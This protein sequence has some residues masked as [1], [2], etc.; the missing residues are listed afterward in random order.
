VPIVRGANYTIAGITSAL[1]AILPAGATVTVVPWAGS[2]ERDL[3]N[4]GFQV[5]FGGTF[6]GL[7]L[8][9]LGFAGTGVS[10]LIGENVKGGAVQNRG[11]FTTPTGNHAPE[12]TTTPAY[13]IPLRT[14]FA[15]TGSATDADNDALTYMWEQNDIG[16]ATGTA[17]VNNVKKDGPLF[18]QFGVAA[19]VSAANSLLY[20]S[21]GEN[22]PTAD[23][24]RVFPDMAQ[25]LAGNTNAATGTCPPAPTPATAPVPLAAIDCYSEFL[26]TADW[27]GVLGDRTLNF[28]LTARDAKLG[29]GGV[30]SAATKLTL[31]P[32]AGPFRV[33]SWAVPQNVY[34]TAPQ[35]IT[36]DVSGTDVAPIN[37]ANVKITLSTDGGATF[38]RVL[39]ESTPNDGSFQFFVPDITAAKAR[40]K[41]EAIGN[42]FFDVSHADVAIVAPPTTPVGGTVPPTLSVVLGTPPAFAPFV[43]GA[44]DDYEASTTPTVIST[45]GDATLSVVDPSSNVPGH[46]VN[47]SFSLASALQVKANAGTFAAVSGSPLT[48]LTY[49]GPVSNDAVAIAFRQ[50]IDRTEPLRTGTYSKTLTYTLSTTNP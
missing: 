30:G 42:V 33:T 19:Q 17:L 28:R 4:V 2:D 39:A 47:G 32:F 1:Q 48:L 7:D 16:G 35:T 14:P 12:V 11:F 21:P 49:A 15:L 45:A 27:V 37:V 8:E 41:I 46:L 6:A 23:P 24:T 3:L 44:K 26:P 40:I 43:P 20:N 13:T 9:P 31:A 29:G 10:G 36:W 25:I 50:H 18:R 38:S 22:M 5:E 34:G